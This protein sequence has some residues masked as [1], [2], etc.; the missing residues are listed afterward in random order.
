[1]QTIRIARVRS[2][3]SFN[4]GWS[5]ELAAFTCEVEICPL[6]SIPV[7]FSSFWLSC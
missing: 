3:S 2:K 7:S 1:M 5:L 6:E 4:H